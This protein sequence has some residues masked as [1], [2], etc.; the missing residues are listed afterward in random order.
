VFSLEDWPTIM[1]SVIDSSGIE[2]PPANDF[3]LSRAWIFVVMIIIGAFFLLNLFVG[4]IITAYNDVQKEEP[5]DPAWKRRQRHSNELKELCHSSEPLTLRTLEG[6]LRAPFI[7]LVQVMMVMV[8]VL[9]L[10]L[11]VV[12]LLL[13]LAL[14]LL[15]LTSLVQWPWFEPLVLSLIMLNVIV[16]AVDYAGQSQGSLD[17]IDIINQFFTWAFIVEMIVKQVALGLKKYFGDGWC[18][19]DFVVVTISII[20]MGVNAAGNVSLHKPCNRQATPSKASAKLVL[21]RC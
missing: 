20:E 4:V 7:K 18:R 5:E 6:G 13:V 8:L 17:T 16:M 3:K 12:L 21:A 9:V 15:V 11:V 14:L 2:S 19:F 1:I 10:V